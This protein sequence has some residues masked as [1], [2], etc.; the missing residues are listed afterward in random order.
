MAKLEL[1]VAVYMRRGM[2]INTVGARTEISL[3]SFLMAVVMVNNN[4]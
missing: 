3:P 1:F 2:E 4:R